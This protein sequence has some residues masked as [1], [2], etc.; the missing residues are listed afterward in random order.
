MDLRGVVSRISVTILCLSGSIWGQNGRDAT[1]IQELIRHAETYYWIGMAERGNIQAFDK[2]LAYL[3]SAKSSLRST[4]LSQA[5]VGS[6]HEAVAAIEKDLLYQRDIAHDTLAGVFPLT[7][8]LT[9]PLFYRPDATGTF[10]LVDDPSVVAV[11][12]AAIQLS[13]K[14]LST[15]PGQLQFHVVFRSAPESQALENEVLY[16]LNRSPKFFVHNLRELTSLLSGDQAAQFQSGEITEGL[17]SVLCEAFNTPN[18]LFVSVKLVDKVDDIHFYE[19]DGELRKP[20]PVGLTMS[21]SQYGLCRDRRPFVPLIGAAHA[22]LLLLSILIFV[23]LTRFRFGRSKTSAAVLAM[24]ILAFVLGRCLPWIIA[25]LAAPL[26]PQPEALAVLA[27]WW[28][29]LFG[30][31][32][33]LLP[34]LVYRYGLARLGLVTDSMR[35]PAAMS[36]F[37][38][39]SSMG[40]CAYFAGP[41]ILYWG[42]KG[43]WLLLPWA[44]AAGTISYIVGRAMDSSDPVRLKASAP[45]LLLAFVLGVLFS[46]ADLL[47]SILGA[48]FTALSAASVLVLHTKRLPTTLKPAATES[49]SGIL[50]ETLEDLIHSANEPLYVKFDQFEAAMQKVAPFLEGRTSHIY[51]AGPSGVGKSSA[52]KAMAVEFEARFQSEKK[53][54]TLISGSCL[55]DKSGVPYQPFQKAFADHFGVNLAGDSEGQYQKLDAAL[56]GLMKFLV[57]FSDIIFPTVDGSSARHSKNEVCHS[58]RAGAGRA[59]HR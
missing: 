5:D 42:V 18:I 17:I 2:G 59:D 13:E 6:I 30:L 54:L 43:I 29:G 21:F 35:F 1:A 48:L 49:R 12:N 9:P 23:A 39:S 36:A 50:P 24:P 28:P 33:I 32:A 55:P 56:G 46:Q 26:A 27:F 19:I 20:G 4:A 38:V 3:E 51:F 34:F 53:P 44:V 58:V 52:V 14:V 22:A 8:F 47:S 11:S 10:E 41:S 45:F 40:L 37:F 7:R 16:I 15:F 57:P 25:T 31:A